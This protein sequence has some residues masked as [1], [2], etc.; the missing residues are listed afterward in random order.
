[1]KIYILSV[2]QNSLFRLSAGESERNFCFWNVA[3]SVP[4]FL[5]QWL[6][7]WAAHLLFD[8]SRSKQNDILCGIPAPQMK[9]YFASKIL[10]K[11]MRQISFLKEMNGDTAPKV[12]CGRAF[13][14]RVMKNAD[15]VSRKS[16]R[17]IFTEA[18]SQEMRCWISKSGEK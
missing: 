16:S 9:I 15:L 4:W 8:F 11:L 5:S 2:R 17:R 14:C 13:G 7:E 6:S 12:Q 3:E 18:L 1:M 10:P